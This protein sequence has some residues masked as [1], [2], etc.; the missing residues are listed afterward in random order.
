M[1]IRG[2]RIHDVY[3]GFCNQWI[4]FFHGVIQCI[5]D[6][7]DVAVV[8]DFKTDLYSHETCPIGQ[9]LD[10]GR[11]CTH[12]FR[13]YGVMVVGRHELDM[14][15]EK[16]L[17][18]TM[19]SYLDL[20]EQFRETF[21]KDHHL[22][23]PRDAPL[24]TLQ[25]DPAVNKRK[26]IRITYRITHNTTMVKS[27]TE[28]DRQIDCHF[29]E[30]SYVRYAHWPQQI[31]WMESLLHHCR[32]QTPFYRTITSL[33]DY[34]LVHVVHV[35]LEYDAIR[36]WARENHMAEEPFYNLLAEKY[37]QAIE[38]H[39]EGGV[40]LVLSYNR[41]NRVVDGLE[42]K[43]RPYVFLEK[44]STK[45][46]EWNAVR[47]MAIAEKYGNGVFVGNF[48]TY[49]MQG[50]TYSYFLMKRCRFQKHVL[51]DIE[52]VEEKPWTGTTI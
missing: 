16:V 24:N 5:C 2:I 1:K 11:F 27:Y 17:Y 44:D 6:D 9:V 21:L 34:P 36:H 35:R 25:F 49:R 23:V 33:D 41:D 15:I 10:M 37:L 51:I 45:G 42:E 40:V 32:F 38:Q 8:D 39:M 19:T 50:S 30:I 48:D 26:S 4:Q 47:D 13:N 3:T 22:Y 14:G 46:R 18:G 52:R 31:V 20:T 12:V 7:V 28:E 43:K 29:T